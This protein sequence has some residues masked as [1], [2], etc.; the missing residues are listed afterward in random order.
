MVMKNIKFYI[1]MIFL[2]IAAV[3]ILYVDDMRAFYSGGFFAL[4]GIYLIISDRRE[5]RSKSSND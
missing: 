3:I 4:L 2:A 5:S 1:G